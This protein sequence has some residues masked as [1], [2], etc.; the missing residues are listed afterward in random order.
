M[1][2]MKA[3][4]C[5]C[6]SSQVW[7]QNKETP[8]GAGL[9]FFSGGTALNETARALSFHYPSTHI[10][11]TFD[12][13]GSSA[14]LRKH[15]AIPAVGDIRARLLALADD[16]Q[17]RVSALKD[18]LAHR[19]PEEGTGLQKSSELGGSGELKALGE[20]N[21]LAQQNASH[22]LLARLAALWPDMGAYVKGAL[23][24][25]RNM[26][27]E[28]FNYSQASI[29]NL[30]LAVLFVRHSG[31]LQRAVDE[32]GRYL[33]IRGRV[34]PVSEVPAHLAVSLEN[35]Q[36]L[37]GQ[38]TF[39]GKWQC[40]IEAPIADICLVGRDTPCGV[41]QP[42]MLES[43]SVAANRE[44][45]PAINAAR[46]L[47]YPIGSFFSSVVANLLVAGVGRSIASATCPKLFVPN[48]GADPELLGLTLQQQV[49]C[50]L[51]PLQ[52]DAPQ[53]R[54]DE[55]ISGIV[56]DPRG[57][58]VGGVPVAFLAKKGIAVHRAHLLDAASCSQGKLYISGDLL[59]QEL[60]GLFP[61]A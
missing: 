39:T 54:P 23:A 60:L 57:A 9:V 30:V 3:P 12:S 52:K 55:L 37:V 2:D 24:D 1:E 10:I 15:L 22:S 20:P 46:C 5:P 31:N 50:L 49:E 51:R 8:Q 11:T 47:C 40:K 45:A 58:Y 29:G 35:G 6:F 21:A 4:Y 41:R 44:V 43:V 16:S 17:P 28:A 53:A 56:V 59:A 61:Q 36:T 14:E 34:I 19:L 48:P 26:A 25:F 18:L 42:A 33:H 7:E 27:G 32:L 13:G 38:H